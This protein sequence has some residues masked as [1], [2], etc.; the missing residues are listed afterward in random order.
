[1]GPDVHREEIR[2]CQDL[3]LRVEELGPARFLEPVW[4]GLEAVIAEDVGDCPARHLVMEVRQG[5]LDPRVAPAAVLGGHA[6]DQRADLAPDRRPSR[7]TTG[8]AVVLRGD[9]GSVPRQQRVRRH[10][11]GELAQHPSAERPGLCGE[12][13]TLIVGE[14]QASGS[15]L[16]AEDAVLFLQIVD[17][18]ALLLVDPTGERDQDE[19]Q[20]MRQPRHDGQATR[21]STSSATASARPESNLARKARVFAS[22]G[23]LDSTGSRATSI[24]PR[25]EAAPA[26]ILARSG[27]L[28]VSLSRP[29]GETVAEPAWSCSFHVDGDAKVPETLKEPLCELLLV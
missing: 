24:A 26:T 14:A 29:K 12:P 3:P 21:R 4:R 9:E 22:I 7:T 20:R 11:R 5:A 13:T 16:L 28:R 6:H 2:C 18:I 10:D 23:F 1:M 15:K 8:T 25:F 17:D 19:L 27:R